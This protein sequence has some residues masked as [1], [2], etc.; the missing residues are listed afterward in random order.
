MPIETSVSSEQGVFKNPLQQHKS[1]QHHKNH[2]ELLRRQNSLNNLQDE[3]MKVDRTRWKCCSKMSYELNKQPFHPSTGRGMLN[4]K[5]DSEMIL[6]SHEQNNNKSS[7]PLSSSSFIMP[8]LNSSFTLQTHF[9]MHY[10]T[11]RIYFEDNVERLH[12]TC[13]HWVFFTK[14]H[15]YLLFMPQINTSNRQM[16]CHMW[17]S[18]LWFRW[19]SWNYRSTPHLITCASVCKVE[20]Q[21]D[22][23]L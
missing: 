2:L 16:L 23:H 15:I 9:D 3:L 20:T 6:F 11:S 10:E 8:S 12:S 1:W 7:L 17:R 18:D 13:L 5:G 22:A 4:E 21:A 19:H 14:A